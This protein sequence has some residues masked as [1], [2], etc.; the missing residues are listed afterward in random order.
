MDGLLNQIGAVVGNVLDSAPVRILV[1]GTVAYVTVVWLATAHWVLRDM[2]RRR[3]ELTVPYLAALGVVLASPVLLPVSVLTYFILRPR[4]TLAEA[5]ERELSE[6]LDRLEADMD[7]ACPG[8]GLSVAE[9][10]L[11]C[12]DCRTRLAHRCLRCGR[13]MGLDWTLCGWCGD[14]F[15]RGV[16][17]QRLPVASRAPDADPIRVR[18]RSPAAGPSERALQGRGGRLLEPGG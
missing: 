15:G 14:D 4:E 18:H 5:R 6:Q 1:W 8:C 12:P 13:T 16:V 3:P 2:R 7:L 17:P 9:D 11:I 10:W